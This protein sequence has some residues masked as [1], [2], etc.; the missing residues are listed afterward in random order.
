VG[1]V[2]VL[3]AGLIGSGWATLFLARGKKVQVFDPADGAELRLRKFVA[4]AWPTM[5]RLGLHPDAS[6][7]NLTFFG[8]ATSALRGADFVQEACPDRQD[9]KAVL[10]AVVEEVLSEAVV[11][12]S[13]T[14]AL[15]LKDLQVGRLHPAR[16][17]VGHPF[18]P[19]HILPLVEVVG[20]D[21]AVVSWAMEFY[22]ALGKEP[23]RLLKEK[24]GHIA[25][26]LCFALY[27]EAVAL[28]AEGVAT[29][30]D[31]DKAIVAGPGPRWALL[32]P[33]M[34]YHLGGGEG[35]IRHFLEHVSPERMWGDLAR[36]EMTPA[37]R[38]V[39]ATGVDAAAHGRSVAEIT[40][41]RDERLLQL[42]GASK[43]SDHPG[44]GKMVAQQGTAA[45]PESSMPL[46]RFCAA[47]AA[48]AVMVH[49]LAYRFGR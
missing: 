12:A 27:Q 6:V 10:F 43:G 26:R 16:F 7:G 20:S 19:P 17:I 32:G 23:V 21:E 2:A 49:M 22:A 36:V 28:V 8:D 1:T 13:S 33:H 30:E 5:V 15:S 18:N 9:I 29:V 41:E 44:A 38:D 46:L 40:K 31:V 45:D 24:P 35:G 14:S 25:N 42:L 37:I 4:D 48:V 11:C 34:T 3:G 47:G 39:V